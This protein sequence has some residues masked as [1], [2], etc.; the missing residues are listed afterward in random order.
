MRVVKKICILLGKITI[1]P[2]LIMI[3][4][5][6]TFDKQFIERAI[7]GQFTIKDYFPHAISLFIAVLFYVMLVYRVISVDYSKAQNLLSELFKFQGIMLAASIAVTTFILNALR[8]LLQT[9]VSID[10]KEVIDE[11][12]LDLK[13]TNRII[14]VGLI[15][16]LLLTLVSLNYCVVNNFTLT[17]VFY[18]IFWSLVAVD[19]LIRNIFLF[20]KI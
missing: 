3:I 6:I 4:Y 11:I 19:S 20:V 18:F 10:Q 14:F 2:F 8:T 16:V 15:I 9:K 7:N 17:L 1:C 13:L 12:I 5:L